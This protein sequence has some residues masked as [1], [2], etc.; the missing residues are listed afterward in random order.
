L[1]WVDPNV[2]KTICRMHKGK[3]NWWIY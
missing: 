2:V 1:V 3:T